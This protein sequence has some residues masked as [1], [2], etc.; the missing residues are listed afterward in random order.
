[1]ALL[2]RHS[3]SASSNLSRQLLVA[4]TAALE[5]LPSAGYQSDS[6]RVRRQ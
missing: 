6:V 4:L 1:M 5:P 3:G 2:L